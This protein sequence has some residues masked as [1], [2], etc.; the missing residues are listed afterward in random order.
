MVAFGLPK[1]AIPAFRAHQFLS[2][3]DQ[4]VVVVW[5]G[6]LGASLMWFKL[7]S[8]QLIIAPFPRSPFTSHV[9]AASEQ[10]ADA[11]YQHQ[12]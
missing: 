10:L 9:K 8:F 12:L 2:D 4:N 6:V 11:E 1:L 3:I 7:G 5:K